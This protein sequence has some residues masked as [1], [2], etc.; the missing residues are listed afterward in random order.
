MIAGLN[1]VNG[2]K[3]AKSCQADSNG[4]YSLLDET[5][6]ARNFLLGQLKSQIPEETLVQ[7]RKVTFLN[8]DRNLPEFPCPFKESEAIG[9]LKAVEAGL[10]T[11]IA[12]LIQGKQ[13]Q[14][15]KAVVDLQLAS[16]FLFSAYLA[17]VGGHGKLDPK[18]KSFIKGMYWN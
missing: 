11:A 5:R 10:A 13:E 12:D 4:D 17:T 1:D 8:G 6:R 18:S 2:T 16:C 7:I 9:A 15:R 14:E 3:D